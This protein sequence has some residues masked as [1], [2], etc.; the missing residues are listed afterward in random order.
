M[1]WLLPIL[2]LLAPC[3]AP[4]HEPDALPA[5]AEAIAQVEKKV[6]KRSYRVRGKRYYPISAEKALN[7]T[8]TG[9]AS[10]YGGRKRRLKTA[11]GEYINPQTSL[12]AAHKTL[13]M[14]CKVKV[15]CLQTGKSVIVRIN[16]RGP[17]HPRRVIDLTTAAAKKIGLTTKGITR[18][19]LE[20]ISVGDPPY[21]VA[22]P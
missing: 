13:P 8:Q 17:F 2:I 22:A 11:N 19:R 7:F 18:V 6:K 1:K 4:Q 16:N 5:T 9:E 15:T 10:W 12:S 20:V 14:P 3:C 21:E